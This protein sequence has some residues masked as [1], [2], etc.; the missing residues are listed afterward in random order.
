[1]SFGGM[2]WWYEMFNFVSLHIHCDIQG[3]RSWQAVE[4]DASS[5]PYFLPS[6]RP[7]YCIERL[8]QPSL[9]D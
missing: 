6:A 5:R 8:R 1:M 9:R 4:D 7:A 3:D 2:K